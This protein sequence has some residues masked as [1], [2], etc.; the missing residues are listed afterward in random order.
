[1]NVKQIFRTWNLV[2]SILTILFSTSAK[3]T[4]RKLFFTCLTFEGWSRLEFLVDLHMH[5][6]IGHP[7][8]YWFQSTA[9]LKCIGFNNRPPWNVLVSINGH[10]EMYWIQQSATL[11]CIGFN[12][13]PLWN[14]LVSINGH[15]EMYWI[16]ST[17][18]LKCI[19]FINRPP[20]NVLVSTISHYEMYWHRGV[21]VYVCVLVSTIGHPEIPE[22]F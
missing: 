9:T 13:Q 1:M 20:W 22:M 6:T 2:R 16:Q 7:E 19:G 4:T 21:V 17:A 10:P 3:N 18:S 11:N 15:P 14:V 5:S 8:M 12:N